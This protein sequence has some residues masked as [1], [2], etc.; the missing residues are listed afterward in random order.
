MHQWHPTHCTLQLNFVS[1]VASNDGRSSI[2]KTGDTYSGTSVIRYVR[3]PVPSAAAGE[4]FPAAIK[5]NKDGLHFHAITAPVRAFPKAQPLVLHA[6]KVQQYS[7]SGILKVLKVVEDDDDSS[8]GGGSET[9]RGGAA[10]ADNQRRNKA[11]DKSGGAKHG[12]SCGHH[13]AEEKPQHADPGSKHVFFEGGASMP[14][15]TT[16]VLSVTFTGKIQAWDQGGIYTNDNSEAAEPATHG[17]LLTHFEVAL[18]R[19]AFPCPD[20]PMCYRLMWQLQS[21]QL[22]SCYNVVASNTA[23]L[24]RKTLGSKSTQYVFASVG[25][26]PAYVLAFAAF[27]DSVEVVEESLQLREAPDTADEG[28]HGTHNGATKM[29]PLR[30]MAGTSS[31]VTQAMLKQIAYTVQEAVRLLE[32]FF[33]SPLPLQQLP[34]SDGCDQQEEMLTVVVAPTMPYISGMEH[35]GCIFLN[36]KIYRSSS[37]NGGNTKGASKQH[38]T[39]ASGA[40]DATRVELIVHELAHHWMGNALGM[41]FVL[42]EGVCQLLE[43]CLGDVIL[44]KPMRKIKPAGDAAASLPP[45][46]SSPPSSAV[47][48]R[49]AVVVVVDTEKGKEFTG[50]SYQ[51]ALNTLRNVVS[52]VGLAAFR[53]RMQRMYRDKVTNGSG[54]AGVEAYGEGG[55]GSWDASASTQAPY[56]TVAQFLAY[57]EA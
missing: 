41:S 9:T 56:V 10:K 45:T 6:V 37:G 46:S 47:S 34:F 36:E 57:V 16:V 17:V 52:G 33:A 23:E 31:G 15:G 49:G 13:G 14:L 21:L 12:A 53:E 4:E 5:S 54:S 24:A 2:L 25:P 48:S 38:A 32:D 11:K 18:A 20:D 19:L 35:H 29:V 28:I 8:G 51:S 39:G 1:G 30:V 22:P 43:Q 44:G 42:K 55:D 26:L 3:R 27:T 50:H 40:D 7:G